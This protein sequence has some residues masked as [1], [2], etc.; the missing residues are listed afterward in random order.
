MEAMVTNTPL[1]IGGNVLNRGAIENLPYEACV[2]VPCLVDA[3]GVHPTLVGPLPTQLA[4]MNASN[5]YCQMLT[6]EAAA[7]GSRE[8]LY[9]AAMMDPVTGAQLSTDEI[10]SLVDELI[11]AHTN[12]G[13][14]IF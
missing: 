14:P 12:A 3:G 2:E 11:E 1:K 9:Q 6:V 7:T 4:A 8:T 10:V 13:F 5:I